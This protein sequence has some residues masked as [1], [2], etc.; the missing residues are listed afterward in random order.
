VDLVEIYCFLDEFTRFFNSKCLS[1]GRQGRKCILSDA[2]LMLIFIIKSAYQV[3]NNKILYNMIQDSKE[4]SCMFDKLPSYQQFNDGL[5]RLL[6]QFTV[7]V[8]VLCNMNLDKNSGFYVVDST[9]LPI[10]SNG[11]RYNC[12]MGKNIAKPGKNMNGWWY[13]F[14]L[15]M[16]VNQN[17][18]IVKVSVTDAST[19]DHKV[20]E[21]NFIKKISGILLADKGYT[22]RKVAERLLIYHGIELV[23]KPRKNMKKTPISVKKAKILGKRQIIE[24]VFSQLKNKLN[25]VTNTARSLLGYFTNV[26]AAIFTYMIRKTQ[27]ETN[28][29]FDFLIS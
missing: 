8:E 7:A 5:R 1:R 10:C 11:Y 14:K 26:F 9:P 2:E 25:M 12:R 13:G 19:K 23:V 17:M 28:T 21:K 6:L 20:L 15:H 29:N 18:E 24:T 27:I 22:S 4:L 3:A 16:M